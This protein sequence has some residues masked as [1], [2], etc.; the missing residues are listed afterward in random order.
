[1]V[2]AFP[3][4]VEP[5]FMLWSISN[6]L[7]RASSSDRSSKGAGKY[8]LD[9]AVLEKRL[10]FSATPITPP[11]V[12]DVEVDSGQAEPLV[13]DVATSTSTSSSTSGGSESNDGQRTSRLQLVFVDAGVEDH[14]QLIDDLRASNDAADLEIYLLDGSRDGVEQISEILSGYEDVDAIHLL[15]HGNDAKLRLGNSTLD[16]GNLAGYAGDFAHWQAS[17]TDEA[18]L[19]LYGCE[20]AETDSGV[21]MLEALAALTGADVAAST[22]DT[23]HASLGGDWD[24]EF[25]SGNIESRVLLSD[26]AGPSWIGLL[27]TPEIS[28]TSELLVNSTTTGVQ[29]LYNAHQAVAVDGLGNTIVAWV[30]AAYDGSGTA[31]MAQRFDSSGSKLGV[32]F[33]V[34]VSTPGDQTLPV[35][36]A[37]D[38]GRFAIAFV[39]S[40][41]DGTGIYVRRF[42]ASG[43]AID[44]ADIL[45][46]AGQESGNQT[47]ASIASNSANQIVISWESDG[48]SEGIYARNFDFTSTPVGDQLAT[49]LLTVDTVATATDAAI[50]INDGGRFVV[51]WKDG[52]DL[53][54]RKYEYGSGTAVASKLDLNVAGSDGSQVTVAVMPSDNYVIAYRENKAGEEGIWQRLIQDDDVMSTPDDVSWT[55]QSVEP[56]IAMDE[57]G[58]YIIS[59]TAAD[60]NGVGAFYRT[61]DSSNVSISGELQASVT[62]GQTQENASV[63]MHDLNNFVVAWSGKGD[64]VGHE[65]GSGIFLRQYGTTGANTAPVA[66]LTAGAP[67]TINEGDSL[68]LDGSNSSDADG[69]T[70]SY[71]WDLDNDGLFGET[72]EPLTATAVVNWATLASFGINDNGTHTIGL[73]VDDGRGGIETQTT[74]VTVQNSAPALSATGNASVLQN[75]T[76]TLNLAATDPGDDTLT[77]WRVDWGDGTNNV[78]AGSATSVTHTY[79]VAGLTHNI[80]VSATDEDGTWMSGDLFLTTN[81][82]NPV[83]RYDA[84]TGAYETVIGSSPALQGGGGV[85]IGPDGLLYVGGKFSDNVRRYDPDSGA[86]VSEFISAG[87]GG[88]DHPTGLAFGPDGNLYVASRSTDQVLRYDGTTG[89]FIDVFVTA[90]LGGMDRPSDLMFGPDGHLYVASDFSDSILRYNGTTGA[91][92]DAFIVTGAGGLNGPRGFDFGPDGHLYVGSANSNAVLKYDGTSGASLGTFV[93]SGLGGLDGPGGIRWGADG[94]LYVVSSDQAELIRYDSA[95][96]YIDTIVSSGDG[97]TLTDKL[98]FTPAHQVTVVTS[99]VAPLAT[100]MNQVIGYTE[101]DSTVAINDIVVTDADSGET[102]TATLTL[103]LPAT[104]ALT[105]GTF[106]ASTSTYVTGTGVWQV[107]GTVTD[108]NAALAAVAFTPATDNDVNSQITVHI[109]DAVT[110]GPADG[111]IQLNVTAQNDAPD[112]DLD[113]DDSSG[114]TGSGYNAAFVEGAGAVRIADLADAVIDDVDNANL[115][116]LTVTITNIQD[117]ASEVLTFDTSGTS[118]LGSYAAGV[119]SLTNSDSVAN[120]QQVLRSIRYE[121]LSQT[122]NTTTRVLSISVGDGTASTGIVSNL[123]VTATNNAPALDLDANDSSGESGADYGATFV[124]GGGAV[125]IADAADAV[126][127]DVDSTNL[128]SLV[129][130]ITNPHDGVAETLTADTTGTS[131]GASFSG[132]VLSLSGSDSVANYQQVLRTIRYN[133]LSAA[134]HPSTRVI[135][136]VANDGSANGNKGSAIVGISA[137]NNA[138]VLDLDA[139]DSSGATG[140]DFNV[141]FIEGGGAV[142]IADSMDADLSDL[143]SGSL[144]SLTITI[145]NLL[146]GIAESLSADTSGTSISATYLAGTL[147]LTGV[148]S[149][150]NYEQVLRTV[151]YDNISLVPNPTT[152]VIQFVANDGAANSNIATARVSI[153]TT[154]NAPTLDLDANDS[155]GTGGTGFQTTYVEGG[156]AVRISDFSDANLN[157]VD[158]ANLTSLT[159][160]LINPLDGSSES[161]SADTSGTSITASYAGGTLTLTGTDSVANYQQVLRSIRYLNTSVSPNTT[162]RVIDIVANDGISASNVANATISVTSIN[163]APTIN[164]PGTQTPTEDTP[165]SIN[166]ISVSDTDIGAGMVQFAMNVARGTLTLDTTVAGGV[167][168]SDIVG[169]GSSS[170]TVT[171]TLAQLNTTL[172]AANGLTYLGNPNVNG[173]DTLSLKASDLIV[174]TTETVNINILSVN[175]SPVAVNDQFT[176]YPD[177]KLTV[178]AGGLLAN[179]FDVDGNAISVVPVSGPSSGTLTLGA[180]GSFQFIPV[181]SFS[182]FVTFS[183]A[184]TDGSATSA[185]ATVVIEVLL[186]ISPADLAS[187]NAEP[188]PE[189]VPEEPPAEEE[190]DEE[191]EPVEE[192][193]TPVTVMGPEPDAP[194]VDLGRGVVQTRAEEILTISVIPQ[195]LAERTETEQ[196][197]DESRGSS[198]TQVDH[199]GRMRHSDSIR[200][201]GSVLGIGRFDSKLL[202]SDMEDM[203]GEINE[204]FNTPYVFAGSF[205]GVSSALSVGYVVWTVRGGLLATSLLAHLPAWSFVDPLLV[206]DEL[207]DEDEADDDSLAEMLDKSES[208]REKNESAESEVEASAL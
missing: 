171:A 29:T 205:A 203:Q 150:A 27:T 208:E 53:Y 52:A 90:G 148:D 47:N 102:I 186:P 42:D 11:V 176:M 143:D 173:V 120:Y 145:T 188:E 37:D 140:A 151:R 72:N 187:A 122:P 184:V 167:T 147:T 131:I 155:S 80:L 204:G 110:A 25:R 39:S 104:G 33:Q 142:R 130:T 48:A 7:S 97:L 38:T 81:N 105:T 114:A 5:N 82:S 201:T 109:E 84:S 88:I 3:H 115:T 100:N 152:R 116:S 192:T 76:Y 79:T 65:D 154:N 64:Q 106:G 69:D 63:A 94:N 75:A 8:L 126:L 68:T 118:I 98:T 1:M 86:F 113:A 144:S 99:N 157:D 136:F 66:D 196:R 50:D 74:T 165:W 160:T 46:N 156:G 103:N 93:T 174:S 54:G 153:T 87:S 123:T 61:Y 161:L 185:P 194:L 133:N 28:P 175:D 34:N 195:R 162:A 12:D 45:V 22:D 158:S 207:D 96:N 92:I 51:V 85:E 89:A 40:D 83:Y 59:Y 77:Q 107:S 168:A 119:L 49:T 36:T 18:D 31:V 170:V 26:F 137:V 56:S 190:S 91:F 200:S 43:T 139:N 189:K 15:S 41:A 23:G 14:Q 71:A 179:D 132:G 67:Y 58:N 16:G 117:G 178:G 127:T 35:V 70:L 112:I 146:G 180:D 135:H 197:H 13:V 181:A 2:T 166:G 141:A 121:N 202:W 198:P 128:T 108:V 159:A 163:S 24:L 60:Q 30:D 21:A 191:T 95:G 17:L 57:A 6:W 193:Y 134:P 138:P 19:L 4:S 125:L 199:V 172:A 78:Y 9:A 73:R 111:L 10:L 183:Y 55:T 182:G 44:S 206:L 62:G 164:A 177:S 101:D 20:L 129:V 124:E 169:N 149:V 32:E